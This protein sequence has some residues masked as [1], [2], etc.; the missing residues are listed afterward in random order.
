[1]KL[2]NLNKLV[3]ALVSFI[4]KEACEVSRVVLYA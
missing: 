3:K 2:N 4:K 1:M